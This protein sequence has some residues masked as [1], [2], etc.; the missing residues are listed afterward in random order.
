MLSNIMASK[1]CNT[2]GYSAVNYIR[3]CSMYSTV[4]Y[5]A[6]YAQVVRHLIYFLSI[7]AKSIHNVKK[8]M[9]LIIMTHKC[10]ASIV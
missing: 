8:L 9:L 7:S 1:L 2:V 10:H 3:Q 6:L 4:H 5:T